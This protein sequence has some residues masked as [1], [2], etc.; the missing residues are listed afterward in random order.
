[1]YARG[2]NPAVPIC[3]F[4]AKFKEH[5]VIQIR[6][7]AAEGYSNA[8]IKEHF[9][10]DVA[11]PTLSNIIHGVSYKK[12]GGER[13]FVTRG[14]S[15]ISQYIGVSFNA[16]TG[17]WQAT[18]CFEGLKLYLG[19]YDDEIEAALAYNAEVNRRGL[20]KRLNIIEP[21]PSSMVPKPYRRY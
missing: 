21:G 19:R 14:S 12:V 16:Q 9:D 1:M 15:G 17:K 6:E 8:L 11:D 20:N 7:M 10:F 4:R 18:L 3:G 5:E 13:T 2:R